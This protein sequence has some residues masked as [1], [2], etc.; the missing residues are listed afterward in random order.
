MSTSFK[1]Y[2]DLDKS[3]QTLDSSADESFNEQLTPKTLRGEMIIA[4]AHYVL[5]FTP[6]TSQK[7]GKSGVLTVTNFRLSFVTSEDKPAEDSLYQENFFLGQYDVCL[8]NVDSLYLFANDKK[9]KLLPDTRVPDKVK[10]LQVL[11]KNMKVLTFSFKFSPVGHGKQLTTGL[12]HHAFPKRHRLLFAYD[13]SEP[14]VEYKTQVPNFRNPESWEQEME[15]T[16]C[17]GW[18]I[19]RLNRDFIF[20]PS[21]PQVFV[22]CKDVSD[23]QINEAAQYFRCKRPPLWCWSSKSGAALVRMADL[24]PADQDRYRSHENTMLESVRRSHPR[25]T[26]PIVIDL[27]K[28]APSPRDLELSYAKLRE[29]CAPDSSR[30][31]WIQDNHFYSLLESCK[32][33]LYVS[34]CLV[35]ADESAKLL[36][37]EI[38]VVLQELEG[39]DICC[40]VSSLTMLLLDPHY[41]TFNG[42]QSLIQKEWVIMGHPFCSR[43]SHVYTQED[44][45][46]S[47]V[48]LLFL[49]CVW[50]ILQQFPTQF[51]FTE[52]YLTTLWDSAHISIFDTFLFDCDKDR[53]NAVNDSQNPLVLRNIWDWGEMFPDKDISLFYNP[54]YVEPPSLTPSE[55][56][57][58]Q[59][60]VSD[61]Q[62]WSQ[63]Y[64][65]FLPLL[66]ITEGGKPQIDLTARALLSEDE[67]SDDVFSGAYHVG[68]FFPF[69]HWRTQTK[70]PPSSLYVNTSFTLNNSD[71]QLDTQSVMTVTH[72]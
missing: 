7:N 49:D 14:Y 60:Y 51:E 12:L 15:R 53:L 13:Y 57:C 23:K 68:S 69:T 63:C 59:P 64:F 45:Q 2:V 1:S 19:S 37:K 18:R 41:R 20:S 70:V 44:N 17:K 46:Q 22:V 31:F 72:L 47:P 50:Q 48:F 56:L 24:I 30:Q 5:L 11:C 40:V 66:E 29:L 36:R 21:L 4:K 33:L 38:T 55:P 71:V 16:G 34:N 8:S 58:I 35:K 43:L 10:T 62:L 42:F 28:D 67:S 32:W 61:L 9:K 65:R 27:T 26:A 25:K 6:I 54:L 39:R 3:D 52:T